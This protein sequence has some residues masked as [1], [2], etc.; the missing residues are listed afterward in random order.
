MSRK[1]IFDAAKNNNIKN[2]LRAKKFIKCIVQEIK[3]LRLI[4]QIFVIFKFMIDSIHMDV[5]AVY[6]IQHNVA[7]Q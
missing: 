3:R 1:E 6:R 4:R 5:G 7:M 2:L